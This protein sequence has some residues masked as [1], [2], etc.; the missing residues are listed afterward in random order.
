MATIYK[1]T[2]R[3]DSWYNY[4]VQVQKTTITSIRIYAPGSVL[5]LA[6]GCGYANWKTCTLK[7][8]KYRNC[9]SS[10]MCIITCAHLNNTSM[11]MVLY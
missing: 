3:P 7:Q 6:V 2:L 10:N 5:V 1:G 9:Q 4:T 8:Y 11:G